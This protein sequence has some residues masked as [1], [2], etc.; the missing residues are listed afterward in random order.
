MP[1]NAQIAQ[2]ILTD[3]FANAGLLPPETSRQFLDE[4]YG[5]TALRQ[6]IRHEIRTSKTGTI[7]PKDHK[8]DI[9]RELYQWK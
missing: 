8:W 7:D 2:G 9:N 4:T 1:T 5:Q 3:T 6:Q